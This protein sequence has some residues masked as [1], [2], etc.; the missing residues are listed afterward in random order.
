MKMNLKTTSKKLKMRGFMCQTPTATAVC[1][2][3]DS[4][5]VIVPRKPDRTSNMLDNTR[6]INNK[7]K[8]TRL[9]VESHRFTH[10]GGGDQNPIFLPSINKEKDNLR[11]NPTANSFQIKQQPSQDSQNQV[12]QVRSSYMYLF[13]SSFLIF[14]C[15]FR[16]Q[17]EN[18]KKEKKYFL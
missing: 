9:N 5:S 1:M 2:T 4:R 16:L 11:P 8:Y 10:K 13:S 6:L 12:F 18:I 15:L 14:F 7:A 3:S 17:K